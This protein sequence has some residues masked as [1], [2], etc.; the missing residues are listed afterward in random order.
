M[1]AS[2]EDA[3]DEAELCH[4]CGSSV[5]VVNDG[6]FWLFTTFVFTDLC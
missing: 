3:T 1:A 4:D 6:S 5:I 2:N